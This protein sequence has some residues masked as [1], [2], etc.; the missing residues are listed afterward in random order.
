MGGTVAYLWLMAA[1]VV[2]TAMELAAEF[3]MSAPVP[4][5]WVRAFGCGPGGCLRRGQ[6]VFTKAL[7]ESR[8]VSLRAP[9]APN[10]RHSPERG[11]LRQSRPQ[12]ASPDAA[13]QVAKR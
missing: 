6:G 11:L 1:E 4:A 3:G 10:L 12:T 7:A 2:P 5:V 8:P 13:I 9:A